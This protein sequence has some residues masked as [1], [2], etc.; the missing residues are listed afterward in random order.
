M[1]K[2]LMIFLLINTLK[3][4][5][6]QK[7]DT[8]YYNADWNVTAKDS[9]AYCGTKQKINDST[10]LIKDYYIAG[11]IQNT[12]QYINDVKKGRWTY[13][14][15]NGEIKSDYEYINNGKNKNW[16]KFDEE[17][18]EPNKDGVYHTLNNHATFMGSGKT[19]NDYINTHFVLPKKAIKKGFTSFNVTF[20]I[21]IDEQGK[22]IEAKE[23][24]NVAYRKSNG[25]YGFKDVKS[26]LKY[27]V[28]EKLTE[29]LLAMPNWEPGTVK[30]KPVKSAHNIYI[31]Y[32]K[33]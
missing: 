18:L 23:S 27:G 12:G 19:P 31:K 1:K 4:S 28:A 10:I 30:G 15:P 8:L 2:T 9:A 29:F 13:Y 5:C 21:T 22:V 32:Q 7:I 17:S 26:K 14:Y 11:S 33:E 6:A 24:T 25:E 20:K 3:I 16:F